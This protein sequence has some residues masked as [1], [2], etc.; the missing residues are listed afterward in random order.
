MTP[1]EVSHEYNTPIIVEAD[2]FSM[3]S[4]GRLVFYRN[5]GPVDG[6]A[7]YRIVAAFKEWSHVIDLGLVPAEEP[8]DLTPH[9]P[10]NGALKKKS[11]SE[12]PRRKFVR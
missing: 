11:S 3:E 5:V 1:Y 8:T 9:L 12:K 10:S 4:D 6:K 2:H 7:S